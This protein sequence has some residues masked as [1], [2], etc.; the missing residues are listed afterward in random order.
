MWFIQ[1]YYRSL[2][3]TVLRHMLKV[4]AIITLQAATTPYVAVMTVFS[5]VHLYASS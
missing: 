4:S 3:P 2:Y 1:G 5:R